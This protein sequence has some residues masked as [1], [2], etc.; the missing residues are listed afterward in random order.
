MNEVIHIEVK[1]ENGLYVL[2]SLEVPSFQ[3]AGKDKQ[4]L[5]AGAPKVMQHLLGAERYGQAHFELV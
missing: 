4:A 3:M 5:I 1:Y 2:T